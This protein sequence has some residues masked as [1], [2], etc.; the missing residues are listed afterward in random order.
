MLQN[1]LVAVAT[2]TIFSTFRTAL[3]Q[4][5]TPPLQNSFCRFAIAEIAA[6]FAKL[7]S[8]SE[9]CEEIYESKSGGLSST[10]F[11]SN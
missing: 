9:E 1:G 7:H 11:V 6:R 5:L 10:A 4:N 2:L 3:Q 8:E